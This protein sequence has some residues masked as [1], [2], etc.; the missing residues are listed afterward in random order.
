MTAAVNGVICSMVMEH[1]SFSL[2]ALSAIS[3]AMRFGIGSK[4]I[5]IGGMTG[6]AGATGVV[7]GG[8]KVHKGIFISVIAFGA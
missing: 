1:I 4:V 7:T 2:Q 5:L 3:Q 6:T 8:V